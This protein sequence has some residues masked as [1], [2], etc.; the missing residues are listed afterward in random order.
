M[1]AEH[2]QRDEK[3]IWEKSF[4]EQVA[5]GAYNTAPVEAVIRTV[6]YY[7][8]SRYPEPRGAGLKF[9]EM[10]CGA[11]PNLIWLAQKGIDV[12]GIDI[13]PTALELTR[14]NFEVSGLTS[15]LKELVE[16]SVTH[17]PFADGT[18]DGIIEA[19]VFQHLDREGRQ[20]A[21]AEVSRLLK[22]G[23]LFVG[24]M[25]NAD[26]SV[27]QTSTVPPNLSD[28]GTLFL[29]DGKSSVYLTNIGLAHFFTREEFRSLLPGFTTVDP[30]FTTYDIPREEALKRGYETYRQSMWTVYAVK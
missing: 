23:G 25:L 20:S 26:H 14:K 29:E 30:C 11:G 19:C 28:P 5:R 22:P 10:G 15:H 17:T 3:V 9:L 1:N 16:G 24:Y 6:S 18:F 13:A 8:R 2:S 7:L 12:S 27:F 21:F 4:A